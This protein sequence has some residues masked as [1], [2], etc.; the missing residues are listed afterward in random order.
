MCRLVSYI[1]EQMAKAGYSIILKAPHAATSGRYTQNQYLQQNKSVLQF[2]LCLH[3]VDANSAP[4][5]WC[6]SSVLRQTVTSAPLI[7]ASWD[8]KH[9]H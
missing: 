2:G 3:C 7:K 5:Y 8:L 9:S 4:Y 1:L 6:Q